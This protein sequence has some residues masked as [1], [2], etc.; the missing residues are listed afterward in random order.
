[1]WILNVD[2]VGPFLIIVMNLPEGKVCALRDSNLPCASLSSLSGYDS[3]YYH[4]LCWY[5]S[6]IYF[7]K[8][9]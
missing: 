7:K 2:I 6:Q 4:M 9:F 3:C 5:I 8:L 1:M